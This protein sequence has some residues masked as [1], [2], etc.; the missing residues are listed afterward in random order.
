M[1]IFKGFIHWRI[2]RYNGL[3][4]GLLFDCVDELKKYCVNIRMFHTFVTH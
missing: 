4:V 2:Y 3:F 1:W